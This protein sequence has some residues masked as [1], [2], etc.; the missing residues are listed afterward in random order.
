MKMYIKDTISGGIFFS[1]VRHAA[2]ERGSKF[3]YPL[4]SA[5]QRPV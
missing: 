3:G 2:N 4:G 5:D 1:F